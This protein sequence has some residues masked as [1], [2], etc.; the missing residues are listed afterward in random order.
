[1]STKPPSSKARQSGQRRTYGTPT[2]QSRREL[3]AARRR[4]QQRTA[5]FVILAAI[6]VIG[7]GV[8]G[9]VLAGGGHGGGGGGNATTQ[10]TAQPTQTGPEGA[11]VPAGDVL[12]S[13]NPSGNTIDGIECG[14]SEQ[15]AYHIHPHLEIFVNGKPVQI[16]A[17]VGIADAKPSQSANGVFV[18]NG[19]CF[20]WIHTHAADGIVHVESPTSKQYRLGNFFDIWGQPLSASQVGPASGVVTAFVDGKPFS[21]NP[22]DIVLSPNAEIQLDVGTPIVPYQ[23][24]TFPKNL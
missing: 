8:L 14:S 7:G 21:G 23:P 10:T 11:P 5:L 18:S 1:M 16:P 4:A 19:K 13:S 6:V 22:A 12:A 2:K 24:F 17:G 3:E 20:Y 9:V 15:L